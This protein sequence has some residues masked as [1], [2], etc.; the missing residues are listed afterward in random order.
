MRS[1]RATTTSAGTAIATYWVRPGRADAEDLAGQEL[2]RRCGA[3][4]QL[5]DPAALLRGD[6]GR[7]PHAVDD[8]AQEQQDD[9]HDPEEPAAGR[10]LRIDR[11][12]RPRSARSSSRCGRAASGTRSSW[13]SGGR[14]AVQSRMPTAIAA[15]PTSWLRTPSAG[16]SVRKVM[17]SWPLGCRATIMIP[18]R[19]PRRGPAFAAGEVGRELHEE[20]L[21]PGRGVDGARRDVEQAVGHGDRPDPELLVVGDDRDPGDGLA[22]QVPDRDRG[23][24]HAQGE[25]HQQDRRGDEER[26]ADAVAVLAARDDRRRSAAAGRGGRPSPSVIRRALGSAAVRSVRRA[27]VGRRRLLR[28]SG[29]RAR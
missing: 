8:H 15:N 24:P 13:A 17:S 1:C 5:H 7:D 12:D 29:R 25:G 21:L 9:E 26:A 22:V 23:Q 3:D 28:A 16:P 2:A 11:L 20:R 4:H 6:A 10:L 14:V 19:S 27:A 18:P